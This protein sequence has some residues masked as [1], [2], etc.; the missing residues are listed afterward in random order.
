MLIHPESRSSSRHAALEQLV[1]SQWARFWGINLSEF[2][3]EKLFALMMLKS[4]VDD[5][6]SH[7]HPDNYHA[8]QDHLSALA[9]FRELPYGRFPFR[10][11]CEALDID[12]DWFKQRLWRELKRRERLTANARLHRV[13][14]Q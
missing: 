4:A 12:P 13:S 10:L 5:A 6:Q 14:G 3:G 1:S 11:V 7:P 2:N 9:W 8:V